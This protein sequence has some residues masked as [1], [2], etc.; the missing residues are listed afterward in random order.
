MESFTNTNDRTRVARLAAT[1]AC[2]NLR[3]VARAV[4]NYYD[5]LFKEYYDA[6]PKEQTGMRLRITQVTRSNFRA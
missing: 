1:C 6:L 5:A 3:R 4:T 2:Q